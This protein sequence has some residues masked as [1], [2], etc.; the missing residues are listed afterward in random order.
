MGS[1]FKIMSGYDSNEN[2]PEL[3]VEKMDASALGRR[4]LIIRWKYLEK[5][6]GESQII[7][8]SVI[9]MVME[10][11]LHITEIGE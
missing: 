11:L 4:V 9:K 7:L 8:D 1:G 3:M 10:I 2:S 6:N 5:N